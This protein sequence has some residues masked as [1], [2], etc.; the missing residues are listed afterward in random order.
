MLLPTTPEYITILS[1]FDEKR[2]LHKELKAKEALR[3]PVLCLILLDG[4]GILILM[5][6]LIYIVVQLLSGKDDVRR[7]HPD[8]WKM[9][10]PIMSTIILIILF[11][12]RCLLTLYF[13]CYRSRHRTNVIHI[14]HGLQS[15]LIIGRLVYSMVLFVPILIVLSM[16]NSLVNLAFWVPAVILILIDGP[17]LCIVSILRTR[18]ETIVERFM[19]SKLDRIYEYQKIIEE[20]SKTTSTSNTTTVAVKDIFDIDFYNLKSHQ[21][22]ETSINK[23]P[24][25]IAFDQTTHRRDNSQ[26]YWLQSYQKENTSISK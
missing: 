24:A 12:L 7:Y 2:T 8:K 10:S 14:K 1:L 20:K 5:I 11:L 9:I 25:E 6:E 17:S 15:I 16:T 26:A 13:E 19:R 4:A 21:V 3:S 22:K 23:D 18:S